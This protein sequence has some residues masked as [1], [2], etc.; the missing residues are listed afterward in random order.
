MKKL[1][2]TYGDPVLREKARP[3]EKV[4]E[5]IRALIR[6]MLE[7]MR[8]ER[9]VGL[10]AEQVGEAVAVCIIEVPLEMDRDEQGLLFNPGVTMPMA[11]INPRLVSASRETETADEGCLSFPDIYAPI[12]RPVEVT[13][14]YLDL[15]GQPQTRTFRKFIAR[16]IQHEMDHLAGVLLVDRMSAMKKI[17]LSGQIKRLKRQTREQL[18]GQAAP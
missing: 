11:F 9:G 3:V 18:A 1:I 17:T 7:T 14:D 8:A 6:D 15:Q 10:A 13:V 16:A 12:Q 4:D 2:H 5:A